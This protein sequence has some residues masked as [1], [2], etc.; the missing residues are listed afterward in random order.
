MSSRTLLFSIR[1][2]HALKIF[3]GTKKVELRRS[4]PKL[5]D[6]DWVVVYASTPIQAVIGEVQVDR[7]IEEQPD[8]LWEQVEKDAGISREQFDS[9]YM[10]TN[11]AY[12]IYLRTSRRL[13]IPVNLKSLRRA[14]SGFRP[15]QSYRYLTSD[16]VGSIQYIG[17]WEKR[18]ALLLSMP[19]SH[20]PSKS[21]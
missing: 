21:F 3:E 14:W 15:P 10:G 4:R 6:G 17:H 2:E 7:I 5:N 19:S 9:Y 8:A 11:K 18:R 20:M 1:P 12:G 13:P 16:Q